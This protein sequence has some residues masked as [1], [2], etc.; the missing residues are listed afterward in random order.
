MYW[1]T[2][3]NGLAFGS[4]VLLFPPQGTLD[5]LGF[6]HLEHRVH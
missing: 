4:P 1:T 6:W 5:T 3:N 2:C